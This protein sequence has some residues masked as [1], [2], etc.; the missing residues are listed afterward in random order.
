MGRRTQGIRFQ[1]MVAYRTL[2]PADFDPVGGQD[3]R[4][5]PAPLKLSKDRPKVQFRAIARRQIMYGESAH[6]PMGW[7]CHKQI[8]APERLWTQRLLKPT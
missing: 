5:T 4:C 2:V 6:L 7:E 1:P 8:R 3:A